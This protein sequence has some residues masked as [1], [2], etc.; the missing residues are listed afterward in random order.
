P[1][2]RAARSAVQQALNFLQNPEAAT[3]SGFSLLAKLDKMKQKETS[4]VGVKMRLKRKFE[5]NFGVKDIAHFSPYFFALCVI[6]VS[7][8]SLPPGC[9]KIRFMNS[10]VAA[11]RLSLT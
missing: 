10:K 11:A 2:G 4:I 7:N 9:S 3:V 5:V 1:Q 8:I 6:F